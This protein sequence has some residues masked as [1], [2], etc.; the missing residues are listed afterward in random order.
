MIIVTII[1]IEI[2]MNS[3]I[4]RKN[5]IRRERILELLR[6]NHAHPTADWVY[7]QLKKE[8]PGLSL[9]T[10]YRNLK[11]LEEEGKLQNIHGGSTFDRY[12]GDLSPHHHIICERCGCVMDLNAAVD[13]SLFRKAENETG[14]QLRPSQITL[15]GLCPKCLNKK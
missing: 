8:F 14:F 6:S 3:S 11:I 15:Y 1:K 5:S 7:D 9:G 2:T 10:V 13:D 12:D 4:K